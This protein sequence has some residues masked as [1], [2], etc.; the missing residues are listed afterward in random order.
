[1]HASQHPKVDD[2]G[3]YMFMVILAPDN[4]QPGQDEPDLSEGDG[5]L[6]KKYRVTYHK[7]PARRIESGT[8]RVSGSRLLLRALSWVV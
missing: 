3:T 1:M 2:F 5:Y 7:P 4:V 8:S 6:I